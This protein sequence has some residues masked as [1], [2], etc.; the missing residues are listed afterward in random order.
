MSTILDELEQLRQSLENPQR[1][2]DHTQ[3]PIQ[4]DVRFVNAAEVNSA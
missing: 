3:S 2:S 1:I 4:N